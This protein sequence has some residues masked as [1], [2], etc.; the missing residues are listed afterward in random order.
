M[1]AFVSWELNVR[2][3]DRIALSLIIRTVVDCI[4]EIEIDTLKKIRFCYLLQNLGKKLIFVIL[5]QFETKKQRKIT[6]IVRDE[7]WR[8]R[9]SAKTN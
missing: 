5:A 7:I 3:G 1:L 4:Y 8:N 9:Y 6:R 2:V